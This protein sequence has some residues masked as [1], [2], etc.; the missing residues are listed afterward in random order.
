MSEYEN[1][2]ARILICS[3]CQGERSRKVEGD[4]LNDALRRAGLA[5][6][7]N[8]EFAGCIGSCIAPVSIGL[9][10]DGRASYV[11][12]GIDLLKDAD[13]IAAT[14]R[15]YLNTRK[16]WIVDA[17]VCGR[18]RECLQTRLPVLR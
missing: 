1:R 17:H 3:T 13:D 12:S 4:T 9:Q 18:L 7:V 14:C 2:S 15:V 16:G 11:F 8:V 5:D 6:Q 10:G